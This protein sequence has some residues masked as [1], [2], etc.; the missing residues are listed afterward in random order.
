MAGLGGCDLV[1]T[2]QEVHLRHDA[3]TDRIELLLIYRGLTTPSADDT[4]IESGVRAFERLN[5][6]EREFIVVE[7]PLHFRLDAWAAEAR[8]TRH[9]AGASAADR[10]LAEQALGVLE[11]IELVEHVAFLD[12]EGR[13]CAYQRLRVRDAA[14]VVATLNRM[15]SYHLLAQAAQGALAPG[16]DLD[17]RSFQLLVEHA[18]AGQPWFVLA[19]GRIV[20]DVPLSDPVL[21]RARRDLILDLGPDNPFR[22]LVAE[23]FA[24]AAALEFARE[25]F[26]GEWAPDAAGTFAWAIDNPTHEYHAELSDALRERGVLLREGVDIEA[27]RASIR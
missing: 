6:G 14:W 25:R 13:P 19:S 1:F 24:S 9:D 12:H 10:S 4:A 21:R 17:A 3:A 18:E 26:H 27:V 20:V 8:L 7:W 22:G 11:R 16:G 15:I 23:L 5:A 2:G